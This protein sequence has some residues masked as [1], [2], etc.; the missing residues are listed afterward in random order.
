MSNSNREYK[1][2]CYYYY[3]YYDHHHH[4]ILLE[5]DLLQ[6]TREII[7]FVLSRDKSVIIDGVW[8]GNRIY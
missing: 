7:Y 3:Y 6:K 8:I 2:Y 4:R 5:Y 1:Y